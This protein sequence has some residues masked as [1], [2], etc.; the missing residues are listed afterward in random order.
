MR[1]FVVAGVV[2][3]AGM[4]VAQEAEIRGV[5]GDQIT[6]F[7]ADDFG[8]AFAYASPAIKGI[9]GTPE[10]FGAMV[11]QGYPMVHR[12]DEVRYLGLRQEGGR[13]VQRVMIR[14]GQGRVHFLDYEMIEAEGGW[15]INGVR[16][17]PPQGAGA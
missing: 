10:R 4:A 15:Q 16:L 9:F 5:I 8:A 14:D 17:L 2:L 7:R 6:A 3:W 1:A 13:Q 11:R 12:P